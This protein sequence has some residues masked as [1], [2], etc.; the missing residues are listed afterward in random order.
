MQKITEAIRKDFK[1]LEFEHKPRGAFGIGISMKFKPGRPVPI[2]RYREK[3]LETE[4]ICE[5]CTLRYAVY[6]I[7]AYCPDC[8]IHNSLQILI[9]DF[10]V[11]KKLLVLAEG[12]EA[13]LKDILIENALEDCVSKFDGFGRNICRAHKRKATEPTKAE[14]ISFQNIGGAKDELKKQFGVDI[15]KF[16]GSNDW[17]YVVLCFQKRHVLEHNKG[18][19]DPSYINKSGDSS[20]VIGRK[21]QVTA[22][23]VKDL[24]AI[25]NRMATHINNAI[26]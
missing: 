18:V 6:G 10:E 26:E 8:G 12:Q 16:L 3:E 4:I 7:F 21:L 1:K 24:V 2:H 20:A 25:L 13:S 15:A 11:I 9:K 19:I 5:K 23:E 14:K 22:S 17:D